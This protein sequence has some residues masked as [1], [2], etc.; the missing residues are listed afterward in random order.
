MEPLLKQPA[1]A[2]RVHTYAVGGVADGLHSWLFVLLQ[3]KGWGLFVWGVIN[4]VRQ[5]A[6]LDACLRSWG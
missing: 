3:L 1:A 2:V 4:V 5:N 6:R